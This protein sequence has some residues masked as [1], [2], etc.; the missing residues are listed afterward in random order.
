[1]QAV[2]DY[3]PFLI[4][5]LVDG[6][7]YGLAAMGLVLTYKTSGVFN[8][9]HGALAAISAFVFYVLH[10]QQNMPWQLAAF[11]AIIV[12]GGFGGLVMERYT[13]AL[14]RATTQNKIVG[15]VGLLVALIQIPIIAYGPTAR[16]IDPFLP[17]GAVFHIQGIA[18]SGEQFITAILG[19]GSAIALALFF[20]R[21][22]LGTAM[23]GVVDDPDLLDMIGQSPNRVRRWAWLIG[24]IFASMSGVL[25]AI[26]INVDGITLG[27]LVIAAFGAA[28]LGAFRSLPLAY[29]GGLGIGLI[30]D[31]TAKEITGHPGL[32]GLDLNIPFI[33]LFIGL[34]VIPRRKLVEVG[35]P[36]KPRPVVRKERDPRLTLSA[37]GAVAIFLLVVPAL[38]GTKLAI[39]NG[40]MPWALVFLSLGLLVRTSGQVSLCQLG[41]AAAGA[42]AFAHLTG[43]GWPWITAVLAAGLIAAPIGAVIAIPAIRLSG[44]YLGLATL[45]FGVLLAQFFY[46][47]AFFFGHGN[48]L[49][50]PRPSFAEN[51][52]PYYYLQLLILALAIGAVLVIERSRLG[53]I[54]R[55]LADSP[56]ALTTAGL[57]VNV[58]RVLV[59]SISAFIAGIAGA[60]LAS[61]STAINGNSFPY[62]Y[63]VVILAVFAISGRSTVWAALTAAFLYRIVPGYITNQ[64]FNNCLPLIFGALAMAAAVLSTGNPLQSE[65]F[66]AMKA[67]A[68]ERVKTSPVRAR[69]APK[70]VP[71]SSTG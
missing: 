2:S 13:A 24:N 45:G 1:V 58:S 42:A 48:G 34:L 25:L 56:L 20:T 39:W 33:I 17:Q 65:R 54:L 7:I 51:D 32:Q 6:S 23:R 31:L 22:R 59:F 62:L 68:R 28:T 38:V 16:N 35:R 27:L 3:I 60:T 67:H 10:D 12:F 15:T 63:S 9:G 69:L 70:R 57:N 41:F 40:A 50:S 14:S 8:F 52:K 19:F 5:G 49:A 66:A 30:Q 46:G 61:L 21:T 26:R 29:V 11:L 55:G 47:K 4:F 43:D 64:N 44:L 71:A 37:A 36:V 53:R 18:V